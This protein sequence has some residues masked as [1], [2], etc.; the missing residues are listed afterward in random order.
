MKAH[1]KAK[2]IVLKLRRAV[3]HGLTIY[4]SLPS[5]FVKRNNIEPGEDLVVIASNTTVQIM[6]PR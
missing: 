5:E 4:V 6:K 3:R 2:N 1:P